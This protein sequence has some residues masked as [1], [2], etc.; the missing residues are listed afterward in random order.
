MA[1]DPH[2]T[3]DFAPAWLNFNNSNKKRTEKLSG[4]QSPSQSSS[5]NFLKSSQESVFRSS[6][7][8]RSA[9]GSPSRSAGPGSLWGLSSPVAR[10]VARHQSVDFNQS[11]GDKLDLFALS[12]NKDQKSA[13]SRSPN[14]SPSNVPK[15]EP[16]GLHTRISSSRNSHPS[17]RIGPRTGNGSPV[18]DADF[19]S[20]SDIEISDQYKA[21][22]I[23]S[24]GNVVNMWKKPLVVK[25]TDS[26]A[27]QNMNPTSKSQATSSIYKTLVPK[28][29]ISHQKPY[30]RT[31]SVPLNFPTKSGNSIGELIMS[32]SKREHSAIGRQTQ[33]VKQQ[34]ESQSNAT[35]N[36]QKHKS[37]HRLQLSK[38]LSVDIGVASGHKK[39]RKGK[40]HFLKTLCQTES[41]DDSAGGVNFSETSDERERPVATGDQPTGATGGQDSSAAPQANGTLLLDG[42]IM[43]IHEDEV[44][45]VSNGRGFAGSIQQLSSSLEAEHRFLREM[46]WNT[47]EH[48]MEEEPPLTEDEIQEFKIKCNGLLSPQ[49]SGKRKE[50]FTNAFSEWKFSGIK[51]KSSDTFQNGHSTLPADNLQDGQSD[52]AAFSDEDDAFNNSE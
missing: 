18:L 43:D 11:Y 49:A 52:D 47:G 6:I 51:K 41:G 40:S 38:T 20:L 27:S 46:G 29:S 4:I 17:S 24:P 30:R 33:V 8:V 31:M 5:L 26:Q 1:K 39:H 19:P 45:N 44:L 22:Q 16:S 37:D 50:A 7:G 23:D 15:R 9:G 21:K 36:Q 10:S 13:F 12:P 42:A 48:A 3:V 34:G 25:A 35:K 2:E 32:G 28:T 14:F